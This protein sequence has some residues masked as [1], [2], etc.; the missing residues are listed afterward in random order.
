MDMK[1]PKHH[2]NLLKTVEGTGFIL[3]D[4]LN[5]MVKNNINPNINNGSIDSVLSSNINEIF[6]VIAECEEEEVIDHLAEKILEFGGNDTESF[7]SYINTYMGDN[8][9]SK[10]VNEL[11]SKN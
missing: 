10:R 2:Y 7:I 4:A 1:I 3:C 9:L 5:N 8:P 6:Q 11:Y